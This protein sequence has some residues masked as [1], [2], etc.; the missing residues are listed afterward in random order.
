MHYVYR[1]LLS[2]KVKVSLKHYSIYQ[3]NFNGGDRARGG[4][5]VLVNNCIPHRTVNANTSLQATAV[6]ISLTKTIRICS[7]YLPPSIPVDFNKLDELL[8]Q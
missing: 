7:V 5:A 6:S 2:D 4:V 3:S 8:E 1:K